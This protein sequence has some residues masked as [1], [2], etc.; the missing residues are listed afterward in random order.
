[1]LKETEASAGQLVEMK[2]K[3]CSDMKM[4]LVSIEQLTWESSCLSVPV[5]APQQQ[6]RSS[7]QR[8]TQGDGGCRSK[9]GAG[10]VTVGEGKDVGG[11][12]DS[13]P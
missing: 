13:M 12:R 5:R 9:S 2:E 10:V 7:S 6:S 3:V 4:P 11:E 1:M 8:E